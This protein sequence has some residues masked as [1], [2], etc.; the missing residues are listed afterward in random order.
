[1]LKL[2]N[3]FEID[4]KVKDKHTTICIQNNAYNPHSCLQYVAVFAK[5]ALMV[6]S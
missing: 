4:D 2:L 5:D 6:R 3:Q 1:V